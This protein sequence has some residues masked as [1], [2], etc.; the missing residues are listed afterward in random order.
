VTT[1]IFLENLKHLT[2]QNKSVITPIGEFW[3]HEF[4]GYEGLNPRTKEVI[5]VPAK[6]ALFYHPSQE[7][8]QLV[9]ADQKAWSVK[10]YVQNL[11]EEANIPR[12]KHFEDLEFPLWKDFAATLRS[13]G[14]FDLDGDQA[15]TVDKMNGR[16]KLS[17]IDRDDEI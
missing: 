5:H 16:I 11:T 12:P 13:Q 8:I 6:F 1:E 3:I 9:F 15:F 2:E 17:L 14:H 7:L 4:E 10:D